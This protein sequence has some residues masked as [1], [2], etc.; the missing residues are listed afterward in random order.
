MYTGSMPHQTIAYWEE[1]S[2]PTT[3]IENLYSELTAAVASAS[4]AAAKISTSESAS[5]SVVVTGS[6]TASVSV[7]LTGSHSGTST[8]AAAPSQASKAGESRVEVKNVKGVLGTLFI[9][10]VLAAMHQ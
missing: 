10:S 1:G 8:G 6:K 5:A 3:T 7:S 2:E 9:S 4:V